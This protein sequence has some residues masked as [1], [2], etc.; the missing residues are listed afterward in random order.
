MNYSFLKDVMGSP[1]QIEVHTLNALLP[2]LRGMT[3]GLKVD[4]GT[5]PQNH[6]SFRILASTAKGT[7]TTGAVVGTRTEVT[8]DSSMPGETNV[9][10]INIL[11]LRGVLTK[12]DQD[13]GPVGTR[14]LGNR[15]LKADS[16]SNVIGHIMIVESGG[17]QVIA[18]PE[19]TDAMIKCTKP[20]VA[21]IDGMAA[22]AAYYISCFAKEI[23]SSR[24][25][26]IVGCIGTMLIWEGRKSKSVE[27]KAGDIQVTIY[28][29]GA[30]EKN[31]EYEQAINEFNFKPAKDKILNPL[32][33]KFKS[34]V[35][36][37][38]PAVTKAQ[39]TGRTYFAS[40]VKGTLIDSIGTFDYA[41]ERVLSL[42]NFKED[43]KQKRNQSTAKEIQKTPAV[44]PPVATV[45][46]VGQIKKI[47][48]DVDWETINNLP[49]NQQVDSNY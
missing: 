39:L 15:L 2:I 47:D 12:H 28:A 36:S 1:W 3:T 11:P 17:G 18:V 5:E 29:D 32:N 4:K 49:H 23:I 7:L 14:T 20:I 40:E 26:D 8:D 48:P 25:Q 13:C 19:L 34:D 45:R 33:A 41:L 10:V 44:K 21:W 9:K 38:R 37:Q 35:L 30:E 43:N 42:S 6:K 22:S 27:N 24:D 46:T 31:V 16:D